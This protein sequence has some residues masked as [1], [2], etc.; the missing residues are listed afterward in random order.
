MSDTRLE[1]KTLRVDELDLESKLNE[2]SAQDYE[3]FAVQFT[4]ACW[5]IVVR[6]SVPNKAGKTMGFSAGN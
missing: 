4:G 1:W 5:T 6:K 3:I 2:L